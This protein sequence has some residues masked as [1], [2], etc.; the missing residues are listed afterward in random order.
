[1]NELMS[2]EQ[3]SMLTAEVTTVCPECEPAAPPKRR[4]SITLNDIRQLAFRK[5]KAAGRPG[6]DCTRFWLEAEEELVEVG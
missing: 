3:G 4:P 5:W 2:K 6:G 1:M